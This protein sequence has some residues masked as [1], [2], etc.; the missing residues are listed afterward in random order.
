[1][2]FLMANASKTQLICFRLCKFGKFPPSIFFNNTKLEFLDE[3]MHLGHILTYNKQDIVRVVKDM[4]RKANSVLC[5]FSALDPFVKCYLIK[6]Y[7]LWSLSSPSIR[8]AEI[9]LNRKIISSK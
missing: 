7:C 8:I 6:T 3:V 2:L 9:A 5:K 1:M 4:N